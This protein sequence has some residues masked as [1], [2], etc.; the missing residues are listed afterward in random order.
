MSKAS[1]LI[2]ELSA[3]KV[4]FKKHHNDVNCKEYL[5]SFKYKGKVYL[6]KKGWGTAYGTIADRL[7]DIFFNPEDWVVIDFNTH[8]TEYPFPWSTL[9]EQIKPFIK[10]I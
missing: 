10:T 7:E 5:A 8:T 9:Q 3:G 6:E 2:N 4:L 1:E